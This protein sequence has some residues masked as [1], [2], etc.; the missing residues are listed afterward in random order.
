[1][2]A[3]CRPFN[4]TP[5]GAELAHIMM[6]RSVARETA[7]LDQCVASTPTTEDVSTQ[8]GKRLMPIK[9]PITHPR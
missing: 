5:G 7:T 2:S 6:A 3:A 9:I 1:M 4:K 8:A